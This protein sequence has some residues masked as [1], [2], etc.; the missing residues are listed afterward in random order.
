MAQGQSMDGMTVLAF[1][2]LAATGA[3]FVF[4]S[5]IDSIC[6]MAWHELDSNEVM[7][8]AKAYYYF[9]IQFRENLEIARALYP[10]D[11]KLAE[12]WE[13]ECDTDNL[14]PWPGVAA[15]G[16][17][18][19]HD[20]FMR[21]LLAFHPADCDGKLIEAGLVYLEKT[22]QIDDGARASSIASYEDGGLS[23]VFAAMLRVPH[24]YG[25]GQRAFRFFLEEHIRFDGDDGDDGAGHGELSRHLPVDDRILPLWTAFRD[26]LTIAVPKLATVAAITRRAP[27]AP[28]LLPRLRLV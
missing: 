16:E 19:N 14:S 26:L 18:M 20:E 17:R 24:W 5:V 23:R 28:V 9:S 13:G 4:D 6:R 8:V 3:R 1:R 2:P 10:G 22:R 15:P 27:R 12:L 7:C 25:K 11:P 21:R